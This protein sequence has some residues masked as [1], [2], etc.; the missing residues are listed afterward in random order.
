MK[1]S[2]WAKHVGISYKTAWRWYHAGQIKTAYETET[3]SIFVKEEIENPKT[4]NVCIYC[5]VSNHSRKK[6]LE[7]Q[8]DRCA[9]FASA[10]GIVV[11]KIYKEVASG[12]NENRK[13]FWKMLKSNPTTIIV[14][15]KDRLSRFGFTYIKELLANQNCKVIVINEAVEDK[16]DLVKDLVS[17][18]YSFCA[19]LYGMRRAKNKADKIR[20]AMDNDK[21]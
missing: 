4:A 3:G 16:E 5:R 15:N 10:S 19:R 20:A 17:I 9:K 8:A 21:T 2:K 12:M 14:E 11:N 18:I 13:E 1:L 6:E 7:Y